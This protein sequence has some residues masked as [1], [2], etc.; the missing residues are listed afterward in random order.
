VLVLLPTHDRPATRALLGAVRSAGP[1]G[2]VRVLPSVRTP[3]IA[4]EL[5]E[6][7]PG[8]QLL[9]PCTDELALSALAADSDLVVALDHDDAFD[10]QALCAAASGAAVI[11]LGDGPAHWVLGD[12]ATVADPREPAVLAQFLRN[13]LVDCSPEARDARARAVTRAC[14]M[15]ASIVAARR[16]LGLDVAQAA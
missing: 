12:L 6:A 13:D 2:P 4:R 8:A 16:L 7:L 3:D 11:V 5:R 15:H 9:G 14:D 1:A 10:R